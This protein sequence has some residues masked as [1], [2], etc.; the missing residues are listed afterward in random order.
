MH[1]TLYKIEMTAV[2][3]T[4]ALMLS[5]ID[6]PTQSARR[7]PSAIAP[8][9]KLMSGVKACTLVWTG[10]E[11]RLPQGTTAVLR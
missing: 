3:A 8:A 7:P 1:S 4:I 2:I 5:M 11:A 9:I 10:D 6:A